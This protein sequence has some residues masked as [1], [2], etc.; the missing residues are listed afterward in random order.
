VI[1]GKKKEKWKK[2]EFVLGLD[3]CFWHSVLYGVIPFAKDSN[4]WIAISTNGS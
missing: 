3:V 4:L 1:K 2:Y